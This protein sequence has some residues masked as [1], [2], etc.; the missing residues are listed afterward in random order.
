MTKD[1]RVKFNK[2]YNRVVNNC[3]LFIMSDEWYGETTYERARLELNR[4]MSRLKEIEEYLYNPYNL[5]YAD[6]ICN[7]DDEFCNYMNK[8]KFAHSLLVENKTVLS[9]EELD[10]KEV[11]EA[12]MNDIKRKLP[13]TEEEFD[14]IQ[15]G[16]YAW[17]LSDLDSTY[18]F[19]RLEKLYLMEYVLL[20]CE[21]KRGK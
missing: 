16:T 12:K 10:L 15:E 4:R 9:K 18:K 1:E 13:L 5:G 7:T 17:Y 21:L 20:K 3:G 2:L 11:K 14:K 19:T 6:V 8:I